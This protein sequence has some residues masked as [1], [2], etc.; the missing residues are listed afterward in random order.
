M[1]L[2]ISLYAGSENKFL[3]K[4]YHQV[5]EARVHSRSKIMVEADGEIIGTAPVKVKVVPKAL[6]VIAK[7][8]W[9]AGGYKYAS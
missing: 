6:S 4:E 3:P 7:K 8:G 5:K 2:F 9:R 1:D